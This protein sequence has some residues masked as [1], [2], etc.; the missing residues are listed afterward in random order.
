MWQNA[1]ELLGFILLFTITIDCEPCKESASTIQVVRRCPETDEE[2]SEFS[3]KCDEESHRQNCTS[4]SQYSYHCVFNM[5]RTL[6]TTVCA[7]RIKSEGGHCFAFD[8]ISLRLVTLNDTDCTQDNPVSC[9]TNFW[10]TESYKY[11]SCTKTSKDEPVQKISTTPSNS[12]KEIPLNI[13]I[14]IIT[15]LAI[16]VAMTVLTIS[17]CRVIHTKC[18]GKGQNLIGKH[19]KENQQ[20]DEEELQILCDKGVRNRTSKFQA[21]GPFWKS[22]NIGYFKYNDMHKKETFDMV[23]KDYELEHLEKRLK[24]NGVKNLRTFLAMKKDDFSDCGFNV[25]E[26]V[27]CNIVIQEIKRLHKQC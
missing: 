9:P 2:I 1:S 22:E 26:R 19:C 15:T 20:E 8:S 18:P 21:V 12:E 27:E 7:P 4:P 16:I 13:L 5:H 23:I 17:R 14:L 10:S 3:R 6:L 24:D 11:I 25:G